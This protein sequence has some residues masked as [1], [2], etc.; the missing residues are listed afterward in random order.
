MGFRFPCYRDLKQ[1]LGEFDAFCECIELASRDLISRANA[2]SDRDAYVA[3]L[4]RRHG[5]CVN[6]LQ[7]EVLS[8][9]VARMY[10]LAVHQCLE[11][12]LIGLRA[13][14]PH[15]KEWDMDGDADR[16][17]KIARAAGFKPTLAFDV[18]QHYRDVRN[19]TVHRSARD[20]MAGCGGLRLQELLGRVGHDAALGNLHAPN[21]YESVCFDDF[22][23]FTRSAKA[24][25]EELC[26]ASRPTDEELAEIVITETGKLAGKL[27]KAPER[28]ANA[29]SGLLQTTYSI[30]KEEADR[31]LS[32]LLA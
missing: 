7:V 9:H 6:R 26:E 27:R 19:A 29:R 20:K 2:A 17:T 15:G 14:H 16:L 18:C 31:I 25:A 24:L 28:L 12:F 4:S 22:L 10:I 1:Q 30:S 23:L 32:G 8:P 13:E 21:S 11:D 5:I 3:G